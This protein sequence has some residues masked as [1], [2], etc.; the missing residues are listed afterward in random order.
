MLRA[1]TNQN[2]TNRFKCHDSDKLAPRQSGIETGP[3]ARD[4]AGVIGWKR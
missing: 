2:G 1:I 4:D 3:L